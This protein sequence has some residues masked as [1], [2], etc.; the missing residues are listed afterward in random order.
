MIRNLP[1]SLVAVLIAIMAVAPA[2]IAQDGLKGTM[3]LARNEC[4]DVSHGDG[5]YSWSGT[6]DF[7]GDVYDVVFWSVGGGLPLGYAPA[8]GYG[9]FNEV[10][11]VY[12]G[13]DVAFDADCEVATFEGDP[14]LWGVNAGLVD[15]ETMGYAA[16]GLVI[17][18]AG[19]FDGHGGS[20]MA[21]EG[22]IVVADDD[23]RTA[24]GTLLIG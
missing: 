12:D 15:T 1:I 21:M 23:T 14:V 11:A 7:D 6:V 2:A 13:L 20:A 8:D 5:V 4:Y 19:P 17:E 18:A 9:P 24:P 10:W 22:A 3:D 16:T